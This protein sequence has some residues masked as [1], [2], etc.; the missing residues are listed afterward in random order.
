MGL[1]ISNGMNEYVTEGIVLRVR[2][3]RETDRSVDVFT[4]RLGRLNIKVTGGRRPLSKLSPHLD[5]LNLV[6]LRLVEKNQFTVVD[7]LAAGHFPRLGEP[8]VMAK[9]LA[10]VALLRT[11]LP[12]GEPDLEM[13]HYLVQGLGAGSWR[14][15]D[16][17]RILGYA[18][19]EAACANCG[20][21][22]VAAFHLKSHEFFCD[23]CGSRAPKNEMVYL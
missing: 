5:V 17:L 12:K 20:R 1:L 21:R 11:L 6:R 9:A 18:S 3:E 4:R 22:P 14:M 13:W 19:E 2:N 8:P 15:A 7:A 16:V 10:T 23:H